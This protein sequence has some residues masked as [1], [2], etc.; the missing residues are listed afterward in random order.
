M[1]DFRPYEDCHKEVWELSLYDFCQAGMVGPSFEIDGRDDEDYDVIWSFASDL[2]NLR[3]PVWISGSY[4]IQEID[5]FEPEG[6]F[7]LKYKDQAVG[8][9]MDGQCWVDEDHRGKGLSIQLILAAADYCGG[10]PIRNADFGIGYSDAGYAAHKA[11]WLYAVNEAIASRKPVPEPNI[12]VAGT[13]QKKGYSFGNEV[14]Q[15]KQNSRM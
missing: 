14:N 2:K 10:S 3:F 6:T 4:Q 11:A 9:Y 5:E 7:V 13:F 8:F 1:V 15:E 12:N